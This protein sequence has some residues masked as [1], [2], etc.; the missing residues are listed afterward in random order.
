MDRRRRY[1]LGRVHKIGQ[2]NDEGLIKALTHPHIV[3]A[4]DYAWMFTDAH[5][6]HMNGRVIFAFAQLTKYHPDGEVPVIDEEH[7]VRDKRPEPNLLIASS[8]FVYIPE[9][10]GIAFQHVWNLIERKAFVH[11][12]TDIVR[13]SHDNFFVD[14]KI[15]PIT[16][17]RTFATR[18]AAIES[19]LEIH[20]KVHPPNPLFGRAWADLKDYLTRRSTTELNLKEKGE[21]KSPLRT[22]IVE[23]IRAML[24]QSEPHPYNSDEPVDVT[25]AAILM[26]ADGYGSGKVI[27]KEKGSTVIIRTSE[28]QKSF[29]FEAEPKPAALFQEAHN[30]FS[31]VSNERDMEHG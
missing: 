19:F 21:G 8:P 6:E 1:Y 26:A 24:D 23:H 9:F 18:L 28:T 10:S 29:L 25:D 4:R 31:R 7:R 5:V 27:G 14:C 15:E 16:D 12:F 17:L 22:K 30:H 2:L 3:H 20:A 13:E 11:R